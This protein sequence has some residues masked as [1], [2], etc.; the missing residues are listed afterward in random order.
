M[1]AGIGFDGVGA[2]CQPM[3][4]QRDHRVNG[5]QRFGN[6]ALSIHRNRWLSTGLYTVQFTSF[7]FA[8]LS[9][10]HPKVSGCG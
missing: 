4:D 8:V 9:Q 3:V 7:G 10:K 2:E 6:G 5:P 1:F